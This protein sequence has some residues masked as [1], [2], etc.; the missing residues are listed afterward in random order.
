MSEA[1]N[2]P[3]AGVAGAAPDGLPTLTACRYT[4]HLAFWPLTTT[5]FTSYQPALA[6]VCV[7]D[8]AVEC[9]PSPKSQ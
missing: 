7:G 2:V 4:P 3:H 8:F 1:E 5:S 6:N 9:V